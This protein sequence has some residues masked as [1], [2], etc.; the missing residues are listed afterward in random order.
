MEW[1][2]TA[3]LDV[4]ATRAHLLELTRD[5]FSAGGVMEVQT[6]ALVSS[7]CPDPNI[8][9]I[10][11]T[12][13]GGRTMFLHT[14]PEH[15]MKRMLCAGSGDIYQIAPVFRDG[16][17]GRHHNPEFTLIEWYRTGYD[18]QAMAAETVVLIK[19]LLQREAVVEQITY[20]DAF[21]RHADIDPHSATV[22]DLAAACG[23]NDIARPESVPAT[24]DAWLDL[25]LTSVV[26]P[27]FNADKIY[28]LYDYPASQAALARVRDTTPAVA[29]RFEVFYG[30]LELANGFHELS[31]ATEQRKRFLSEQARYAITGR[32]TPPVDER[33]LQA[34]EHGL[35]D[36]AGVALGFDRVVML[37]AG[38]NS[39]SEV[40]AF[41]YDRA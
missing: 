11:A 35:P 6:P 34:L 30:G 10:V 17:A 21:L 26:V 1:R 38:R 19:T 13:H 7:S 20:A 25:L 4:L 16:E 5:F 9:S 8:P 36:C 15:A 2:P 29:E 33:L 37:A 14:S 39:L 31:D 18:R 41:P 40:L 32:T 3:G 28:V 22:D 12:P 27:A 24:R 23:R